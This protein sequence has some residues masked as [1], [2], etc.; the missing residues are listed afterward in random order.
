MPVAGKTGTASNNNDL[1]FCG[2]TPYYTASVWS[3][4]DNNFSQINQSYQQDIWR[5]IMERIHTEKALPYKEFTIPD[6]IV[7]AKICTKSGK[8][9]IDGI[10]DHAEGGSTVRTEYF[11]KGTVP[12]EK[13][14]V[15]LKASICSDSGKLAGAGCPEDHVTEKVLLV[16]SEPELFDWEGNV[17]E[18]TTSDTPNLLPTGPDALCAIHNEI[19]PTVDPLN[20]DV[21]ITP[22]VTPEPETTISPTVPGGAALPA[23]EATGTPT[24]LP[25]P[26]VPAAGRITFY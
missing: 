5:T 10:C 12:L 1:W 16:K 7:T 24:P 4:F 25:E 19:T 20:P 2:Y 9:A 22:T 17:I 18:Y 3:G 21:S 23:P 26:P 6:S 15:H 14:D 13:C 11:A 8:L